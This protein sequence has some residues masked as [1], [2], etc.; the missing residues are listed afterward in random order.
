[1]EPD[2]AAALDGDPADWHLRV[3]RR[4]L[5]TATQRSID[6]GS[7]L[8]RAA[9]ALLERSQGDNFTVQDVADEAGQS[10]R[11]LYQYFESKDD[12]LL[13]VFEEAMRTYARLIRTAVADLDDPLERLAGAIVA[14]L[15][16]PELAGTGVDRGLARLRLRLSEVEPELVARSQEPVT[17]LVRELVT[18]AAAAGRVRVCEPD[19]ATYVVLALKTAFITSRTLG[20]D[21]GARLPTA[22]GLASFCLAGLGA[23]VDDAWLAAVDARLRF[24]GRRRPGPVDGA[25]P[26]DRAEPADQADRAPEGTARA[27]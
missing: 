21:S 11:T 19:E 16:M 10:L 22:F 5:R 14:A 9:A 4:S 7:A 15:R 23:E 24:P 17:V 3:V 25:G 2:A 13:A 20:D 8:I 26:D 18:E 6:R 1:M 27:R 12:L